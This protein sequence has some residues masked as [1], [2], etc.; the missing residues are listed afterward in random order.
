MHN[1]DTYRKQI[2]AD[3]PIKLN[4][5]KETNKTLEEMS[6][7]ETTLDLYRNK[8]MT[9]MPR[10]GLSNENKQVELWNNLKDAG[11][12]ILPLTIDSNTRQNDYKTAMELYR[13]SLNDES[14]KLNGYPLLSIP[15]NTTRKLVD[16]IK[17][18][19]SLRHGTPDARLLVE[20]ALSCGIL[21]IEG[22][23][24]SYCMPYSKN[25]P[26]E[27]SLSNWRYVDI[28][29]GAMNR[30]GFKV[31]RE[32][33][34]P[35]TSTLVPPIIAITIQLLE[36]IMALNNGVKY[37]SVSFAQTGCIYQDLAIAQVLRECSDMI[38]DKIDKGD[39]E[40]YLVYHQWMGAFP[41]ERYK[42]E[43]LINYANIISNLTKANKSIL[44][45]RDEAMGVPSIKANSDAVKMARY[46]RDYFN[47]DAVNYQCEDMKE[48][49]SMLSKEVKRLL[50]I[51]TGGN[52]E[53]VEENVMDSIKKGA[54]DIPFSPHISNLGKLNARRSK[55][56]G[57]IRIAFKGSVPLSSEFLE[58]ESQ[59]LKNTAMNDL[60]DMVNMILYYASSED[61]L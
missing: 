51:I 16:N 35:L 21:E 59:K 18:P 3:S 49:I 41:V 50:A 42:A 22:G 28:V 25:Y 52:Y 37:F 11:A 58:Y 29:C 47:L 33:F 39:A 56:D 14:D 53:A 27:L 31:V 10:G 23:G 44:K 55:K 19:V 26:L 24:I 30:N 38:K 46:T 17:K 54:I 48:E 32:S 7:R 1:I 60:D 61:L 20:A 45:T 43:S 4:S 57:S 34:G 40:I 5:I 2:R 13:E 8:K 12:D 6:V 36:L 9:I 15:I